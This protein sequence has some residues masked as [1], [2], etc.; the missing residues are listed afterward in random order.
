MVLFTLCHSFSHPTRGS[1][2]GWAELGALTTVQQ[3]GQ[4]HQRRARARSRNRM[5]RAIARMEPSDCGAKREDGQ[6]WGWPTSLG[7]EG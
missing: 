2:L 4:N 5:S 6:W 7:G 3:R 1:R